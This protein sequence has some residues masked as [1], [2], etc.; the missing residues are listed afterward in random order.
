MELLEGLGAVWGVVEGRM[1]GH[2]ASGWKRGEVLESVFARFYAGLGLG[3]TVQSP[4]NH[5]RI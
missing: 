2:C 4:Y 5:L 3:V 1:S